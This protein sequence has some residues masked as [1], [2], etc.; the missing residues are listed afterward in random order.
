MNQITHYLDG[1]NVYG[2]GV[3]EEEAI[4]AGVG[5]LLNVQGRALLP[6]DTNAEED[7]CDA[8]QRGFHCFLAGENWLQL[9]FWGL[10]IRFCINF[11]FMSVSAACIVNE[12]Y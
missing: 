7:S 9:K 1:S 10:S 5:G 11:S 2:S 3:E 6:P 12:K 4:R 8:T